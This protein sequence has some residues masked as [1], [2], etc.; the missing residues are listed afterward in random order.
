MF[1]TASNESDS[2]QKNDDALV[3][4]AIELEVQNQVQQIQSPSD[5]TKGRRPSLLNRIFSQQ[6]RRHLA[7]VFAQNAVVQQLK[8]RRLTTLKK[9]AK[10]SYNRFGKHVLPI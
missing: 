10:N 7:T 8:T 3:A 5:S 4:A 6:Q 2:H 1:A 9:L